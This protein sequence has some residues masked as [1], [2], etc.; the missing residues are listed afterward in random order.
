MKL[1][2]F[3][4][5]LWAAALIGEIQC[6]YKFC[7]SD[8]KPS[9]K[10]EIIYGVSMCTGI[11]AITGWMNFPDEPETSV[12]PITTQPVPVVDTTKH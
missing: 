1:G 6:I 10:R 12:A 8:F 7:T 11:G 5:L 3:A 4:I 9:Y 2:F